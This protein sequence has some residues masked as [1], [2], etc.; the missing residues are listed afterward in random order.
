MAEWR[1]GRGWTNEELAQRLAAARL[2]QRNF[3]A[4]EAEMTPEHAWSRHY[5]KAVIAREAPGS[6]IADGPFAR[7]SRL[8]ERYAFSDPRIARGHF[9]AADPL[10]GRVMLIEIR[11][12]GLRYLGAVK[13]SAV[14]ND[15]NERQTVRGFRYDTLEGHFERGREWF[16]LTKDH[17]S[18]D[19]T[20][21]I[22][23]GWQRG[24]LPNVWSRIGFRLLVRRYQRAWHRLAHMRLRALLGSRDLAPLPRGSRLV[25]EGPPLRVAPV[26]DTAEGPP[27]APIAVEDDTP[28]RHLEEAS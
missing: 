15:S 24:E 10:R 26:Q 27:P 12:V 19:V 20:F 17:A 8:V 11:V 23:A 6:P 14:R 18:G 9:D 2:R 13:V 1:F 28:A 5:S 4:S 7:A 21:T 16:L 25:H 22:H 3:D